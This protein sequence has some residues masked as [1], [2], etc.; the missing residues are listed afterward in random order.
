MPKPLPLP[1]DLLP[2]HVAALEADRAMI[3]AREQGGDVD[4]AREQYVAAALALRAHPIW[5][6][7]QAAQA[8][9]QTWQASLDRAKKTLDGEA[10]AA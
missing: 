5:P 7:A 9:A 8:H 4:A 3:Q 1:D 6:E 10:A 2:L